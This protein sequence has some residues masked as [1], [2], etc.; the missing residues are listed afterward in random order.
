MWLPKWRRNSKWS[1][2]LPPPMEEC[3]KKESRCGYGLCLVTLPSTLKCLPSLPILINAI[4]FWW[5]QCSA[6]YS[7]RLPHFLGSQ[8]L[9]PYIRFGVGGTLNSK[10][11]IVFSAIPSHPRCGWKPYQKAVWL[12]GLLHLCPKSLK[13]SPS[14]SKI[15]VLLQLF[16]DNSRRTGF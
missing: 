15:W 6:R 13:C 14:V 5:W 3:R 12:Q 8:S 10:S 16:E 9:S 7:P 1:H 11:P 4:S 2:T